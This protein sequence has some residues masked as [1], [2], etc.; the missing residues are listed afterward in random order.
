MLY[1]STRNADK[2][3]VS[4]SDV[5]LQG[6][7][8]D[9]GLFLPESYPKINSE[10]WQKIHKNGLPAALEFVWKSFSDNSFSDDFFSSSIS[11]ALK[12]FPS[13]LA[14][15]IRQI[16]PNHW[17]L[18]LSLGPTL[19][20][21]DVA[22]QCLGNILPKVLDKDSKQN[23]S[24]SNKR[25][26]LGATSGDTGPAAI[27]G[28][29]NQS[30]IQTV[31]LYPD[32][33]VSDFQ[34]RQMTSVQQKNIHA[35]AIKGS[36]DVC[37]S[38]VKKAFLDNKSRTTWKL[39][40]INS[41]NW[42]RII[43]QI[44]YFIYSASQLGAPNRQIDVTVPT[45]NFGNIFSAYIA[46]K[47]GVTFD[48]ITIATNK[49]N[50]MTSLLKCGY[51][52]LAPT[53]RT[54]TPSMDV[55]IPSNLERY[56]YYCFNDK[57]KLMDFTSDFTRKS[58]LSNTVLS[59]LQKD[60]NSIVIEEKT[61]F[62]TIAQIWKNNN[63]IIDPHTATSISGAPCRKGIP[64]LS[65]ITASYKKFIPTINKA[66]QN[67]ISSPYNIQEDEK[68]YSTDKKKTLSTK[69]SNSIVLSE[70]YEQLSSFL[71]GIVVR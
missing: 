63:L 43:S 24:S 21:K 33:G 42:G 20:F 56:L 61:I 69:L 39:L 5:L 12:S 3:S 38:L 1:N 27:H 57:T 29:K 9:G 2:K 47:M 40:A 14:L 26:I 17:L 13:P 37:Q 70:E 8:S 44:G 58:D 53:V 32:K 16:A 30:Q 46:K 52:K 51:A 19:A 7:A 4:F 49:N 62:N 64:M 45:G 15:P 65:L 22:M 28:F 11:G 59:A 68:L 41:I 25:I 35:I 36:F 6:L 67:E 50:I 71:D 54:I 31:I 18:D 10:T 66:L 48:R 55:Q 23:N 34:L 60:F